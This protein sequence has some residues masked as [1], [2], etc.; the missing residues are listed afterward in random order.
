MIDKV[1]FCNLFCC[2]Q[3]GWVVVVYVYVGIGYG[4]LMIDFVW[5]G[6]VMIVENGDMVEESE[7]FGLCGCLFVIDVDF[8]CFVVECFCFLSFFDCVCEYCEIVVCFCKI[9]FSVGIDDEVLFGCDIFCFFYVLIGV[10]EFDE[11]CYEVYNIQVQGFVCWF[12]VV[13]IFKFVVG[14]LGGFDLI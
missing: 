9:E 5:D 14:I 8:D 10:E 6:Y 2:V 11:C 3:L 1:K 7:W 4:E 13:K 12:E